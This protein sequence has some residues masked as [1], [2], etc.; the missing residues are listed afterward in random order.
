MY[1]DFGLLVA[2]V[3]GLVLIIW[4]DRGIRKPGDAIPRAA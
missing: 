1:E 4:R 3:A 2:G